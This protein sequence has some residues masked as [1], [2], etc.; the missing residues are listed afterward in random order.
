MMKIFGF[1]AVTALPLL[2]S[3]CGRAEAEPQPD[4]RHVEHAVRTLEAEARAP[5]PKLE[6]KLAKAQRIV[7][8]VERSDPDRIAGVAERLLTR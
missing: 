5:E 7:A 2:L 1:A 6:E 4:P 3:A 8:S